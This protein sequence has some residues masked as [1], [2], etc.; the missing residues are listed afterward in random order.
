MKRAEKQIMTGNAYMQRYN[1]STA[2]E[3]YHVYGSYSA[4]KAR[5]MVWCKEKAARIGTGTAK[6]ISHNTMQFTVAFPCIIDG[7]KCIAI[8]TAHN[9]YLYPVE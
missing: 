6:I 4:A 5:A 2:T 3:L 1:A 8:E 7:V 9:S